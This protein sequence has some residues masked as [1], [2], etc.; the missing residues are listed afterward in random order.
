MTDQAVRVLVTGVSGQVGGALIARRT[1]G[2]LLV[3]ASRQD[4]DLSRPGDIAGRLD[5]MAPDIVINCAAYTAV[6]QA[7]SDAEAAHTINALAPGA[8]A[9]WC[10]ERNRPLIQ[11]STDYVFPGD[12]TR[13]YREDDPVGP[14]NVYGASKLEGERRIRAA[15]PRHVILRTAWVYAAGGK[16]FVRTMLR[17]G[18]DRDRLSVVDDQRGCPTSADT[19]AAALET[20]A[21]RLAT[22][23]A[24]SG[25]A[26]TYHYVDAG[27]TTWHGFAERIFE[28]AAGR[29]GRRPVVEAIPTSAYPT[30]AR[31]PRYSVLDTR[32]FQETFGLIP[33][34]WQ[35][36]LDAVLARILA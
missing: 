13:P 26:G 9:D 14:I 29:W 10:G 19:I 12:A 18:K 17:V 8:I 31:R 30:P 36:S 33:P 1:P 7:E 15:C 25:P 24:L 21:I 6:D 28:V 5:R 16:N 11:V 20:I 34:S 3:A 35:D 32:R 27:E 2:L 4:L 22:S 23:P